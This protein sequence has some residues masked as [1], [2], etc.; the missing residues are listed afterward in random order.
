MSQHYTLIT[1]IVLN[2]FDVSIYK[3][4]D[5]EGSIV[6][7]TTINNNLTTLNNQE[8]AIEIAQLL[9]EF[10]GISK[11]NIFDK[12]ENLLLSIDGTL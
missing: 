9:S 1:N 12:S 2:L 5:Y 11:I 3:F 6:D 10:D 8:T 7:E 4:D